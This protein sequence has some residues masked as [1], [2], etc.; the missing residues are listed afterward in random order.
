MTRPGVVVQVQTTA[1]PRSVPTNTGVAFMAGLTAKGSLTP[2][3]VM[4][5]DQFITKYGD[6]VTYSILYDA[7]DAFF[8]EGGNTVYIGRVVGPA[9]VAATLTLNN[10]DDP[11][12][13]VLIVKANA[14]GDWGNGLKVGVQDGVSDGSYQIFT[15]DAGDNLLET[16]P[17]LL[18]LADAVSWST[19]YSKYLVIT[20]SS[21]SGN[22]PAVAAAA[23]TTGTD[24]RA[25]ITDTQWLAALNRFT[26]DL[27]PGQVMAPGRTT[28]TGQGQ[29]ADHA[30]ANDRVAIVD[31]PDTATV[32]TLESDAADA[33]GTGNGQYTATFTPWLRIP[34][35]TGGT[36]R[37][38]PPSSAVAGVIARTDAAN[39]AGT[40]AAGVNG[41]FR[42][43]IGLSQAAFA[44]SDREALNEAGVNVIRSMLGGF[45]IYGFRSLADPNNNPQW[46]DFTVARYLMSLSARCEAVG[47]GYVFK[48]IDGAGHLQADYAADLGA[49]C[50]ADYAAGIIFGAS[51][52]D[53]YNV[54]TGPSVNTPETI[55][56]GELRAVVAVRPSPFAEL[57]S[58]LI[59]N[60]PI[61]EAVA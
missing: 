46:L 42:S 9:A 27:G 31:L 20:L 37:V 48:S 19:Q 41:V 51:A 14:P 15:T 56:D 40:A 2:D 54:D 6:R 21:H 16:S 10:G 17:D 26:P 53:A 35:I 29:L 8:R 18:T 39:N 47:E 60:T 38:I 1:P 11:P 36:T 7:V 22:P 59:V 61:T 43:V 5:L 4:S 3:F 45:R 32:A 52:T 25:S 55:A 34:G 30:A 12:T 49:V 23:L 28:S 50:Q 13:S 58:I 33:G 57:V 44:E 24:D